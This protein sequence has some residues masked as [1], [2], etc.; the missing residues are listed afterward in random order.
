MAYAQNARPVPWLLDKICAGERPK[1]YFRGLI[2]PLNI[3]AAMVVTAGLVLIVMRFTQGLATVTHASDEQPWGLFL[4]MGLFAGV[5]LSATGFVLGT[6]VYVFGMEDYHPV[7]KNAILLGLLGY[8]FA[9]VFLMIDLGRPWRIYYP[10]FISWGP[11][12]VMFLVAWH[13]ALYLSVQFLEFSPALFEWLGLKSLRKWALKMTVG[14][15]I[16]GIILSTLHQSALGAMFLL[17]PGKIHPL[18][19]S[20]YIPWL[21]LTSAIATGL[22]MVIV[23]SALTLRFF[24]HRLGFHYV[25]N[26]D[27]MTLGMG[28][29]AAFVLL[30]YLAFKLIALG[31]ANNWHL[32]ATSWGAWFLVELLGFAAL[33]C[34]LLAIGSRQENVGMVRFGAFATIVGVI[35]NRL[36][37][38]LIAFN[39]NLPHREIWNTNEAI[40]VVAVFTIEVLVYRWIV[41]RMPILADHPDYETETH[42]PA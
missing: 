28:K 34:A 30:T 21:F 14:L 10:M 23:V 6:A 38:S 35:M 7:V 1:E 16:F 17:A 36:N 37:I 13:V 3:I 33:P 29:A 32:L 20:Q 15:T 25:V 41:N 2:T 9:V 27:K 42:S 18:W 4:S 5:P 39:W 11:A 31:A 26:M 19:Y 22:S 24:R 12:S 8:F 40:V